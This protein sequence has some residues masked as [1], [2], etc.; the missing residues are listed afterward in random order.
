MRMCLPFNCTPTS[1]R[2]D[3][4]ELLAKEFLVKELLHCQLAANKEIS[5]YP[6]QLPKAVQALKFKK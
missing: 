1:H 3:F 2:T 4:Q 6:L 5:L